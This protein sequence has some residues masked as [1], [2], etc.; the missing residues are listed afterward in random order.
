MLDQAERSR[1]DARFAALFSVNPEAVV[2]SAERH[3]LSITKVGVGGVIRIASEVFVVQKTAT[4]TETD[5]KF[6]VAKDYQVTELVLFSLKTGET[7]YI[8][9]SVDDEVEISFT[10]RKLGRSDLGRFTY[11]DGEAIDLDDMDEIAE[12][13][14]EVV[15]NGKTYDYDDDWPARYVASDGRKSCVYF[16]EFGTS[17]MGW[18]TVEAW[19]N[20]GKEAGEWEYEVF[21][22]RNLAAASVEIISLG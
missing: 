16:Y 19:S 7:R 17:E 1:F 6:K 5:A 13:E 22:S 9:W 15:L 21:V 2:P 14:W 18:L 12:N 20:D 4:Y 8:E 3:A 10:E 11:D